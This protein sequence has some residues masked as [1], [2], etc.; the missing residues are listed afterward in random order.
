MNEESFREFCYDQ[1]KL[2]LTVSNELYSRASV[3]LA[4]LTVLGG[5]AV[6]QVD[7]RYINLNLSGD[8]STIVYRLV[9]LCTVVALL[10][11]VSALMGSILPRRYFEVGTADKWAKWRDDYS[12]WMSAVG[13]HSGFDLA[14]AEAT[15]AFVI[16]R[17]CEA[18]AHNST[19]NA[20]RM[21]CFTTSARWT[22]VLILCLV[23]FVISKYIMYGRME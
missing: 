10:T 6:A 15:H 9:G 17:L 14:L 4:G 21:R 5:A 3:L 20:S 16:Q 2:S 18:Q 1:Y 13:V 22:V 23:T 7:R 8:W 11:A 19:V 12:Q